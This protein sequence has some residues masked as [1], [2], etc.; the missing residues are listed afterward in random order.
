MD[1]ASIFLR[2]LEDELQFCV[3]E[4]FVWFYGTLREILQCKT[5]GGFMEKLRANSVIIEL[6]RY[7]LQCKTEM[8]YMVD[9]YYGVWASLT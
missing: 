2:E 5:P 4:L 9:T 6:K 1:Y 8:R 3:T 7:T